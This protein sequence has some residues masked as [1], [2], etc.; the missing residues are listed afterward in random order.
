MALKT[1]VK[2]SS[3][4][5]L[6]DARYC[7]GMQVNLMGFS[8]EE[9]NK[10]FTSAQKF[11]EITDWLSGVAFV[12]EFEF[13]HPQN[14]LEKIKSYEGIDYIQ[15][16]EEMHLKMLVNSGYGIILKEKIQDVAQLDALIAKA[17]SYSNFNVTLLLT[18]DNLKIDEAIKDKIK[19]LAEKCELLLGF[20]LESRNVLELVAYTGVK[21]IAME[22]GDEIKPGLKDFDELA[23]ILEA[24]EIE[25]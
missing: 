6:S 10:N 17:D 21:G 7:S 9:E 15:I 13:S 19:T 8:L 16:E 3:V 25:D 4:N 24:L 23:E 14:I 20:G 2:I 12:A 5:N 22:G 18:S 11:K 1:F